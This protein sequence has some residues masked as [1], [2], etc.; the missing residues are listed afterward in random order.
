MGKIIN[1]AMKDVRLLLRDKFSLFWVAMFPLLFALFF[2][3]I[4]SGG[5]GSM[6]GMRIAVVDEDSTET[7]AKFV[8][9]LNAE[10]ALEIVTMAKDS[11]IQ[12]VRQGKLSACVVLK[13]GFGDTYGIFGNNPTIQIAIDPSRKPEAAYLQGLLAKAS[14]SIMQGRYSSPEAI[15]TEVQRATNGEGAWQ[16]LDNDQQQH[17]QRFLSYL[18]DFMESL[19]METPSDSDESTGAQG[20]HEL[21]TAEIIPITRDTARP[22]SSFEIY[23][24]TAILWALMG[25]AATFSLSLVKERTGGTFLRLQLA[26]I[27][28]AHILA[29]KGL[30]CLI[31]CI[32]ICVI[33]LGIGNLIFGVRISQPGILAIAV[34]ASSLCFVG[35]M[36]CITVMGKTEEAVSG[37]GWGILLVMAM[38]GGGMV[39]YMFMPTW[40]KTLSHISPIKWGILSVEGGI[41]REFS[42]SE[43]LLPVLVLLG[44]GALFFT[45]GVTILTRTD[46]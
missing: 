37:A 41:W 12:R 40:M 6:S 22:R 14:F 34:L 25:C 9:R 35:I 42:L 29:G 18:A 24:A 39:P 15:R 46:R 27:T 30:A 26:P 32:S 2:G 44:I 11:A 20:T 4:F 23:F 13:Q 7:S 16:G 5:S 28:R 10:P 38:I 33:L 1:L 17:A 45:I 3:A 43:I 31:T 21:M 19:E 8:E 36:M